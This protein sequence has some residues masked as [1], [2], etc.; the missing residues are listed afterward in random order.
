MLHVK[1]DVSYRD[2]LRQL[3]GVRRE[4]FPFAYAMALTETA[5][6]GQT[7]GRLRTQQAF[8]LH[9]EYIPRGIMVKNASKRELVQSGYTQAE[10]F[11]SDGITPFMALHETGGT[12]RAVKGRRAISVPG[13]DFPDGAETVTG[14]V[15]TQ[16]KPAVMLKRY[17]ATKHG[18]GAKK[19]RGRTDP[20]V[21][22]T[23]RGAFIVKRKGPK[24]TPLE[25]L[26]TFSK[27][28]TIT[29][30]WGLYETVK[31]TAKK[32]FRRNLDEALVKALASAKT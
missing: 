3:E 20:F 26:Y 15:K 31:R 16:W 6:M 32:V 13:R 4:Q 2:T 29:A 23:G 10:V 12:K 30:K 18:T 17:N 14:A 28:A 25:F 1:V 5:R 7:A 11:T 9:T 19:K 24:R 21:L 27:T 8:E 22:N